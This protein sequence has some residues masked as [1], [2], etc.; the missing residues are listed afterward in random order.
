M[1]SG[2]PGSD[3]PGSDRSCV[4]STSPVTPLGLS[5]LICQEEESKTY[6]SGSWGEA[7]FGALLNGKG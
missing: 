7:H 3:S 2:Q 5:H 6:C 1:E 4:T